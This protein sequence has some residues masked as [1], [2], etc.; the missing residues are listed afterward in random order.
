[1]ELTIEKLIYGGDGLA[2][3]P[4]D[5]R[6]KGKAVF[7]P[8]VLPGEQVEVSVTEH[9]PGFVRARLHRVV[10]AA[11]GRVEP[12]CPYF[13]Q[14]GGC[15][16]QQASYEEQLSIKTDILRE[17]LR[18]TA[19][20]EF[21]G[22]ILVHPSQPWNYRNRARMRVRAQPEFAIGYNRF[23]SGALLP[24]RE[25][26]IGGALI[27][28]ALAAMWKLGEAGKVPAGVV[29]VEFFANGEDSELLLEVT[30]ASQ[31]C[32]WPALA[33]FARAVREEIPAIVGV[34]P[35]QRATN[36]SVARID[37][38]D[39]FGADFGSDFLVYRTA[40]ANY[41]VSAGSF[42]Q[43]NR[44]LVDEMVEVA[45][46]DRAGGFALDLYAGVGLFSLAL[47]QTFR[48]V[49][50]VE[51]AAF[52]FHD[53]QANSPSNV[54]GYRVEVDKFLAQVPAETRFDYVVVDPPRGGLGEKAARAAARLK[55][56][57]FTYVSCDPATLARD[58]R[59]LTQA[60]YRI[61]AMHLL[62]VFPQTFH[63]ETVVWL[64]L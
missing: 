59:V 15:Q 52:S 2:H 21:D 7:V 1:M 27:N 64:E 23:T 28:R 10:Q 36:A 17:T 4:A 29:E 43:T 32:N 11:A 53:L 22:E 55:A 49:A 61:R 30:L 40:N 56:P 19:K 5:A 48:Q 37:V 45:M 60:G 47:S 62:D 20:I 13:G 31:S 25:C 54:T 26:P 35:F 14:C 34:V 18:R 51:S 9:K 16:Y 41:R 6:G 8:F 58:L 63:I 42:F 46:A 24:V 39:K 50:A 44:F 57:Q 3:L 12:A 33:E 38:P